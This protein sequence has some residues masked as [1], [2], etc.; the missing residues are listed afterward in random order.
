MPKTIMTV[1]DA[2]TMRRLIAFTLKTAGH[3]V[4]EADDGDTAYSVLEQRSVDL[5]ITDVNMPR[6]NGVELTQKLRGLSQFQKTPILLLT[7][8]SDVDVKARARAA[9]ATGWIVKPFKQEQ[10]VAIVAKVLGTPA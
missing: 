10:F 1:D 9:G 7:T 6:M 4:L 8:E 5:V 3:E 2:A